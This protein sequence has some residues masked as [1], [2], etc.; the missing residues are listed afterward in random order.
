MNFLVM[1]EF[2][3]IHFQENTLLVR[4]RDSPNGNR[5]CVPNLL[6]CPVETPGSALQNE[7]CEAFVNPVVYVVEEK[8]QSVKMKYRN[9]VF[10]ILRSDLTL[11][12]W[13]AHTYTSLFIIIIILYLNINFYLFS[14]V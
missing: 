3:A 11:F 1:P 2:K 4:L 10:Q 8:E 7:A 12:S 13:L 14:I 9:Q 5:P 6:K